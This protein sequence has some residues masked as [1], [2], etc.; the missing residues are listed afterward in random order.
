[1]F[2][3]LGTMTGT[4]SIDLGLIASAVLTGIFLTLL[5]SE[6]LLAILSNLASLHGIPRISIP[7]GTPTGACLEAGENPA[8]TVTTV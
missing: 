8:G 6:I 2:P 5:T 4:F 3:V 1:M 7:I